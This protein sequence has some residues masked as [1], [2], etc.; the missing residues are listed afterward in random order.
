MIVGQPDLDLGRQRQRARRHRR[1]LVDIE[2]RGGGPFLFRSDR[3][4]VAQIPDIGLGIVGRRKHP[5]RLRPSHDADDVDGAAHIAFPACRRI[6]LVERNEAAIDQHDAA[7]GKL[8]RRK[9]PIA[10]TFDVGTKR[11]AGGVDQRL[12]PIDEFSRK[13]HARKF[14]A[15]LRLL[16]PTG[17]RRQVG[18]RAR[19]ARRYRGDQIFFPDL[20]IELPDT[21]ADQ[22][23]G[24]RDGQNRRREYAAL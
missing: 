16:R 18:G 14:I 7:A 17:A 12:L 1:F 21:K 6:L 8:R 9:Y 2:R 24:E 22:N 15:L 5:A 11:R 20:A 23:R 4:D 13:R 10:R 3:L 19:N